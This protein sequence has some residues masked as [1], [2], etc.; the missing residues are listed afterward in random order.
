MH[1]YH[2]RVL[3]MAYHAGPQEKEV[4]LI[5]PGSGFSHMCMGMSALEMN[6]KLPPTLWKGKSLIA[7]CNSRNSRNS[8]SPQPLLHH[9]WTLP[10]QLQ[11]ESD[12]LRL[13]YVPT[14]DGN[15]P[16]QLNFWEQFSIS[17]HD[18]PASLTTEK[19][20]YLR[21]YIHRNKRCLQDQVH[22]CLLFNS[23]LI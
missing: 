21:H 2:C 19:L 22:K 15:L 13:M 14:F 18:R 3:C 11:G 17:I 1:N 5:L 4:N 16:N 10:P 12:C 23:Q 8:F 6:L 7:V 9:L 20:I